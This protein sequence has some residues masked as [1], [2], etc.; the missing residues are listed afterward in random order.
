MALRL[1][2]VFPLESTS[3]VYIRMQ[4]SSRLMQ[5][6]EGHSCAMGKTQWW[7]SIK[8]SSF[9]S[10]DSCVD[11]YNYVNTTECHTVLG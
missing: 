6:S 7:T 2:V 4:S 8:T 11:E 5:V 10:E 9:C 3:R 1:L